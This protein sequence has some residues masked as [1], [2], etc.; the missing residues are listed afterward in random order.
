MN[1]PSAEMIQILK[2]SKTNN[3]KQLISQKLSCF[4]AFIL[5]WIHKVR[6]DY[7]KQQWT[8]RAIKVCHELYINCHLERIKTVTSSGVE[9]RSTM[10]CST[11][12][13]ERNQ[14]VLDSYAGFFKW[15]YQIIFRN[16]RT[17][18]GNAQALQK[19]SPR[20]LHKLSPR[21]DKGCHL[22]RSR[23]AKPDDLINKW[24]LTAL[25]DSRQLRWV[26]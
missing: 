9:R 16:A 6:F 8:F 3:N 26:F 20:A 1:F 7:N 4:I 15:F 12:E 25:N 24:I 19:L 17:D 2:T 18:R 23:E 22:E 10:T 5:I 14:M 11:T 13:S 21:A